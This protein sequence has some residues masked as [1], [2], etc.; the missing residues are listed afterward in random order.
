MPKNMAQWTGFAVTVIIVLGRDTDVLTALPLGIAA[1]M[2][3]TLFEA[4]MRMELRP[5]RLA[6]RAVD[7]RR[8]LTVLLRA[9]AASG[10]RAPQIQQ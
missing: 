2:L 10:R 7:L 5:M 4:A 9:S 8:P 1:G 3:A 6:I